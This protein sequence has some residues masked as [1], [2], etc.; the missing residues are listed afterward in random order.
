VVIETW[1]Y[2]LVTT[3]LHSSEI[4]YPFCEN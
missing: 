2:T 3:I 4:I 1:L